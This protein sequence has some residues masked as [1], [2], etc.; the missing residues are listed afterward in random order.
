MGLTTIPIVPGW[1][2]CHA[3]ELQY[4]VSGTTGIATYDDDSSATGADIESIFLGDEAMNGKVEFLKSSELL[5]IELVNL[6]YLQ[7]CIDFL[8]GCMPR[9]YLHVVGKEL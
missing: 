8:L 7:G 9:H 3:R 4:A 1:Y 5:I 2:A 6:E